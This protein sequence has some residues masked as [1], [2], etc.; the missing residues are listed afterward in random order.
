MRSVAVRK[1][2][3]KLSRITR[4]M[5]L[6]QQRW[7]IFHQVKNV[8]RGFI[9]LLYSLFLSTTEVKGSNPGVEHLIARG[10]SSS[11]LCESRGFTLGSS[12]SLHRES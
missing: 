7:F 12:V 1:R 2:Y 4:N 9:L 6:D 10:K 5:K 8:A 11:T 3:R